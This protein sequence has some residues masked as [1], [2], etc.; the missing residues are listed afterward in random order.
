MIISA[1]IHSLHG[2][3][4]TIKLITNTE[5]NSYLSFIAQMRLTAL[6]EF[7]YLY[8]GTME[9][10]LPYVEFYSK[11]QD[12]IVA[13]AYADNVAVGIITG[14]PFAQCH[15]ILPGARIKFEHAKLQ[16]EQCYYIGE[17]IIF[18]EHRG[19]GLC[20]MLFTDI[21]KYVLSLGYTKTIFIS[22][23]REANHPFKPANY[24]SQD[25]IWNRRGYKKTSITINFSWP[26]YQC[27]GSIA[28]QEHV[29]NYWM[30]N[31]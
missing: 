27:D 28:E 5:I 10:E 24:I 6:R 17:V 23:S 11:A 9:A 12:A 13:I 2:T 16:P 20:R 14:A 4:Y 31:L 18:P 7:P 3:S 30:K 25:I 1:T 15:E 22:V 21:E 29:L 19:K 26:T 8:H